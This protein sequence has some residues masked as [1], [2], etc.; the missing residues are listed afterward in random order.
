[1]VDFTIVSFG[2]G[3][4]VV[5]C[6]APGATSEL[7]FVFFSQV[8]GE[9]NGRVIIRKMQKKT[10]RGPQLVSVIKKK[11]RTEKNNQK[12]ADV[13]RSTSGKF[14]RLSKSVQVTTNKVGPEGGSTWRTPAHTEGAVDA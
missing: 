8:E 3:P 11:N 13:L 1:M 12:A 7:V 2:I 4:F 5:F 10:L 6:C 14:V 9:E